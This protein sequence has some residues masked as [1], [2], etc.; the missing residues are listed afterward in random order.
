M[1]FY[2][3]PDPCEFCRLIRLDYT[4]EQAHLMRTVAGSQGLADG[5]ILSTRPD[6]GCEGELADGR[7]VRGAALR[8]VLMTVL[9]RV[10]SI[11][12]SRATLLAPPKPGHVTATEIGDLAMAFLAEVCRAQDPVLTAISRLPHWNCLQFGSEAGWEIRMI[13]ALAPIAA[14]AAQRSLTAVIL[15]AGS[16]AEGFVEA[17]K[18]LQAVAE[19]PRGLVLRLW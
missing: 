3:P 8:A 12:G 18:E 19:V 7:G 9:W 5:Q 16:D 13:P 11:P 6:A 17:Q 14:E 4:A 2:C 15:D 10:L 1:A